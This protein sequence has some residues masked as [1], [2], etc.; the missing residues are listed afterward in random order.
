MRNVKLLL[1]H[2]VEGVRTNPRWAVE[3][4]DREELPTVRRVTCRCCGCEIPKGTVAYRFHWD[5]TGCGSWTAV[6]SWI[7]RTQRECDAA[8]RVAPFN[9]LV[10]WVK[11]ERRA[12]RAARRDGTAPIEWMAPGYELPFSEISLKAEELGVELDPTDLRMALFERLHSR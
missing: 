7:H 8:K 5:Y 4:G 1:P 10:Q 11:D 2:Q 3:Y 9:N 12:R 6:T